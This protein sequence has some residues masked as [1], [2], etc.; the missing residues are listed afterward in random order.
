MRKFDF[1]NQFTDPVI[2]VRDYEDVVFKNNTFRRVFSG[3]KNI[4][5]FAH[6]MNFEMSLIDS[7]N[8]DLTSP[9]FQAITSKEN[10]FARI[11]YTD[12]TNQNKFYDLTAV[13]RGLYTII[14]LSDV[15]SQVQ[16]S[17]NKKITQDY[18]DKLAKLEEEN[19]YQN[20]A[21]T[22]E[23]VFRCISAVNL[24]GLFRK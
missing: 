19:A 15:S 5:R 8:I 22:A 11:Q 6:G 23:Q 21:D 4:R 3:F 1:F 16:L 24:S 12:A 18:K 9:L 2:I 10:F 14:F 20:L 13:K 17:D 7:E